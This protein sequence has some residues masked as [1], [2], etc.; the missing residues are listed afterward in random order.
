[1]AFL[2]IFVGV[3][4][5]K[6]A[7]YA[8]I[9]SLIVVSLAILFSRQEVP[10]GQKFS[11]ILIIVLVSLPG[12]LLTLFQLT[13]LVTGTGPNKKT[14]WCGWYAWLV[15]ILT[16]VY[17]VLLIMVAVISMST[18]GD[19]LKDL[20]LESMANVDKFNNMTENFFLK[21]EHFQEQQ[22]AGSP[23]PNKS[24]ADVIASTSNAVQGMMQN[25][26]AAVQ[27]PATAT[28]PSAPPAAPAS[29]VSVGHFT[30]SSNSNKMMPPSSNMGNF[31]NMQ[32]FANEQKF[33]NMEKFTNKTRYSKSLPDG[34][35]GGDVYN[36]QGVASGAGAVEPFA[37]LSL[38]GS[39]ASSLF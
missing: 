32:K 27:P 5:S 34:V 28:A 25:S 11:L 19:I 12:I 29:N 13:C 39:T 37:N 4:Q 22:A 33:G 14:V 2:D 1:M 15:S 31:A 30:N 8:I 35:S 24:L 16:I 18:K 17:C 26:I 6:Y 10:L 36:I 23:P 7:S 3:P 20:K 38:F 21:H 9:A